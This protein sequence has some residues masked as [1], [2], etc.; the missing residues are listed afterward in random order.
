M[1]A[2]FATTRTTCANFVFPHRR[3]AAF[4]FVWAGWGDVYRRP[5][6]KNLHKPE[7]HSPVLYYAE[8]ILPFLISRESWSSDYAYLSHQ[9]AIQFIGS[10][11]LFRI[12]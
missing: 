6:Q 10:H 9:V 2:S 12:Y 4:A 8:T 7:T 5:F 1:N 11:P 3:L